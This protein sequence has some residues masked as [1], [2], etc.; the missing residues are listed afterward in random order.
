MFAAAFALIGCGSGAATSDGGTI[1]S[2]GSSSYPYTLSPTNPAFQVAWQSG[3]LDCTMSAAAMA[4]S[5]A[6]A[7]TVGA[8]TIY[9]GWKQV[10]G[11]NQ[12][13]FLARVDNG[14]IAWCVG[15]EAESPDGRAYGL[16]WDGGPTLYVVYS[17]DGGGTA[18]DGV[19]GWLPAYGSAGGGGGPKVAVIAKHDPDSGALQRATF[20]PAQLPSGKINTLAPRAFTV[21]TAGEVELLGDPTFSTLNPDKTRMCASGSEYP[22]GY[23]VRFP[24]D[25]GTPI[26]AQTETCGAVTTPCL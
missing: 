25:L 23:R 2:S 16:A 9:A 4:T 1:D 15:V 19:G 18:L 6:A 20:V 22:S 7:V 8:S 12:D 14:G 13:P 11:N 10:A 26:C 17:V 21:T 3:S 24:A 5:D